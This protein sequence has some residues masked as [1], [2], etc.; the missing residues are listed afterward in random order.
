MS[1]IT[2]FFKSFWQALVDTINHDGV[3]HAGYLAFLG[4][5]AIFPFLFFMVSFAGTF[6]QSELGI[7]FL[8]LLT[9]QLPSQFIEAIESRANEIVTGP[10]QSLVTLAV[11]GAIWTA[12]S[13]VEGMRTILNRAYRV[14]SPP[15]YL[16]RRL[17]SIVQFLIITSILIAAML[18]LILAPILLEQLGNFTG[19]KLHLEESFSY[20]RYIGTGIALFFGVMG[21]YCMIPNIK[22]G[23]KIAFPGAVIVVILWLIAGNLLSIY[24]SNFHQVHLIYGSLAGIIVTLLFFYIVNMIFIFGAEFNYLFGKEIGVITEEKNEIH[25]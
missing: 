1:Y 8:T 16:L 12:S 4:L 15:S 3:E 2:A 9:K 6:G 10:P 25:Q 17:L 19:I 7:E 5:I 18:I 22:Y 23:I 13:A 11:F 20:F 24:I 21:F 14:S